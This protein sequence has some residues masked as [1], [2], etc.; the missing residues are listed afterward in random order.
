MENLIN[1]NIDIVFSVNEEN[2][3]LKKA[4]QL[5][6]NFSVENNKPVILLYDDI[7]FF[8]N[9]ITKIESCIKRFYKV[10]SITNSN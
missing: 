6:I 1:N 3:S 2:I 4:L 7:Y 8:V 5:S 10:R 9:K